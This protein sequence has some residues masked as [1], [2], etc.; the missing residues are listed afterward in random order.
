MCVTLQAL[1]VVALGAGFAQADTMLRVGLNADIR[2]TEPGVNR[3]ENTDTVMLHIVEGLVAHR[4][5]ASVGPLL[6]REVQ[7]SEDGLSYTFKLREGVHFQNGAT[8]T[9]ADVKWTWEHYLNPQTQWRC[10]AEFDGRGGAKITRIE[11]PDPLTVTFHLDQPSGLFLAS[12]ARPDCA[13]SGILH[14]DSVAA[15][16]RWKAPIGTGPFSLS[17]WKPG[18]FV[19]LARFKDYSVREDAAPD[20]FTGKKQAL[21]DVLRFMIIPDASSAKAALMSNNIDLLPNVS[22]SDAQEF[23]AMPGIQVSVS[24]IMAICGLLF[25]TNDPLLK[26]VRIRQAIALSLDYGQMVTALSN[27]LSEP[28][29]SAIPQTSPFYS[30]TAK[31][32]YRYDPQEAQR[33]LKDA[34]YHGQPIKMIVNKRYSQMFDM[35]L[36]S[37]AMAQGSGLNIEME[38]LEWGT[39]LERY[40]SGNYQMMS[41]SYTSRLDPA[42]G[43][44]SLM[45]DKSKEPRKVWDNPKAQALL[46]DAV[47][48]N[49]TGKRQELF[50][51][52]HRMMIHDTPMVIIYNGT[53]VG[54]LRDSVRGYHSWPVSTPRLWGVSLAAQ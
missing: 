9:S 48:Q 39:Q 19:E 33:L 29:N 22:A 37:Q 49:D 36:L 44:D 10:L 11:T 26:D 14:P 12:M 34:G 38:T 53:V 1:S 6:A 20:G 15:D 40:Q 45:G 35:G 3:D 16:G 43:F 5:D 32:G 13:G 24:P 23:K 27:G 46:R 41:F 7:Q 25:Q 47:R 54:A 4:E 50:D 18:Q 17:E 42:L 30:A 31:Q 52:L 51:Q 8:L 2:S 21:V 28:N